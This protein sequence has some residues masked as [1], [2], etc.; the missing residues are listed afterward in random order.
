MKRKT[1]LAALLLTALL[2]ALAVPAQAAVSYSVSVQPARQ[3]VSVGET[4]GVAVQLAGAN[5]WSAG[6]FRFT[7]DAAR[8]AFD[9][10]ASALPEN[11]AVTGAAGRVTLRV[12]GAEKNIRTPI[13]LAF[14]V[15]AVGEAKV[16]L[17]H[18][19]VDAGVN[20][21]KDTPAAK[22]T[23]AV[24]VIDCLGEGF[25]VTL[26][27]WFTGEDTA[28][29]GEDYLFSAKDKNYT[30]TF[31]GTTMGGAAAAVDADD[32]GT[33]FRIANVNGDIV[34]RAERTPRTYRV[35]I[36]GSAKP[37][38]TGAAS[39]VYMTDYTFTLRRSDSYSYG[40]PEIYI[41]GAAFTGVRVSGSSY[42]I[43]GASI[44]GNVVIRM[45]RTS[46]TPAQTVA[47][48]VTGSGAG[49]VKAP[50]TAVVGQDYSFSYTEKEGYDYELSVTVGGRRVTPE[51][52]T[53]G[54]FLLRNVTAA[55]TIRLEK[56]AR[57]VVHV[58]EYVK[59]GKA[60]S[61]YLVTVQGPTDDGQAYTYDGSVMYRSEA[62]GGWAWLVLSGS[63]PE[64][65]RREAPAKV[66]MAAA[67]AVTVSYGGDVNMSGAVDV[68]DAQLVWNMY[69]ARYESFAA[70]SMEKFLRADMNGDGVLNVED[71]AAAVAA[72][73]AKQ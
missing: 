8:L 47:I 51:R 31:T 15:I 33:N 67:A 9:E 73:A 61:L 39:A 42:T 68:N 11:C 2:T 59:L 17:T 7:Y 50:A 37:D 26:P 57:T 10:S 36:S 4:A 71:A 63:E 44:T 19:W 60:K 65:L 52:Q 22:I 25:R 53:D 20:A 6:E 58:Q 64:M 12:Y 34:V 55:I 23:A 49:D 41:G 28:Y 38:I 56:T 21:D 1:I 43:P 72:G 24:A 13:K 14:R 30:Y 46:L 48:T 16:T 66:S 54:S 27:D 29:K 45:N 62:Y 40:T 32:E 69:N 35:S 5:T 18:A 3:S 70:M